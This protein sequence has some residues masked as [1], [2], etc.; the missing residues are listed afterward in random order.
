MEKVFKP[1]QL[2]KIRKI[3]GISAYK[4]AE[5]IDMAPSAIYNYETG[6]RKPS[7][8][9][10]ELLAEKLNISIDYFYGEDI[11]FYSAND[12]SNSMSKIKEDFDCL[13]RNIRD[14]SIKRGKVNQGFVDVAN[15]INEDRSNLNGNIIIRVLNQV[16][17]LEQSLTFLMKQTKHFE[18]PNESILKINELNK[19]DFTELF[20]LLGSLSRIG[21]LKMLMIGKEILKQEQT[22]LKIETLN[23]DEQI[24]IS[25]LIEGAVIEKRMRT[26]NKFSD[27]EIDDYIIENYGNTNLTEI[28]YILDRK[29]ITSEIQDQFDKLLDKAE[30]EKIL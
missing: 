8:K 16:E 11:D 7:S 18:E 23:I 1:E 25:K 17:F 30:S 24:Q 27:G 5:D 21:F 2:K 12:F 28:N 29:I 19:N 6:I 9:T 14:I 22:I 4:L 13:Y 10:I 20:D 15:L 26:S 3:R